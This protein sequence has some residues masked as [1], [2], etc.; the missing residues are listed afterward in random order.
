MKTKAFD[1]NRKNGIHQTEDVPTSN[2]QNFGG[3]VDIPQLPP[4]LEEKINLAKRLNDQIEA[5]LKELSFGPTGEPVIPGRLPH[6][7][8]L[9][10]EVKSALDFL[11]MVYGKIGRER[12]AIFRDGLAMNSTYLWH[13]CR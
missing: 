6:G 3:D 13:L 5:E 9:T 12:E 10:G 7:R 2:G 8:V 1:N 11:W 4:A